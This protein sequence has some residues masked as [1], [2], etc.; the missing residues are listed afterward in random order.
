MRSD[1]AVDPDSHGVVEVEIGLVDGLIRRQTFEVQE[2]GDPVS[3]T[4]LST[5]R[6]TYTIEYWDQGAP[7][8]VR[9]PK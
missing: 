7:L 8:E 5:V 4:G 6:T 1:Q 9:E 3:G 2:P